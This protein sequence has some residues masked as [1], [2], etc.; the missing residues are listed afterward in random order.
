[1]KRKIFT[2]ALIL[3]SLISFSQ[4]FAQSNYT[5]KLVAKTVTHLEDATVVAELYALEME[6]INYIINLRNFNEQHGPDY[7]WVQTYKELIINGI[8][9]ELGDSV[10]IYGSIF[11]W[12]DD[13]INETVWEIEIETIENL[14]PSY[15]QNLF[16][17]DNARWIEAILFYNPDGSIRSESYC[18]YSLQ[19]DT[20]IDNIARGKLYYTPDIDQTYSELIGYIHTD[21]GKVYLRQ[22]ESDSQVFQWRESIDFDIVMYDFTLEVGS[23]FCPF[24][25]NSY[26][27][28]YEVERIDSVLL[29][30]ETRKRL[31][32]LFEFSS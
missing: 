27:P 20:V 32:L 3:Y 28:L 8:E 12:Y 4:L 2:G 18:A 26:M 7:D 17:L 6:G 22:E 9:Y 10:K 24:E 21:Q 15:S 5:G 11:S 25:L 16:P 14:I 19:G 13:Y 30:N 29:G 23:F 1:M 31:C